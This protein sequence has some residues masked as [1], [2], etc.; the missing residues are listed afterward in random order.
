MAGGAAVDKKPAEGG[1]ATAGTLLSGTR[2]V[3]DV[4]IVEG[5]PFKVCVCV[6]ERCKRRLLEGGLSKAP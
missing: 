2:P 5:R 3:L 6:R 4:G 1:A